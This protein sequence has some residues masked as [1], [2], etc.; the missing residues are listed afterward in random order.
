MIELE[1]GSEMYSR[2]TREERDNCVVLADVTY[3]AKKRLQVKIDAVFSLIKLRRR[4]GVI[5]REAVFVA[6]TGG[7]VTLEVIAGALEEPHTAGRRIKVEY[8][9]ELENSVTQSEVADAKVGTKHVSAAVKASD[10]EKRGMKRGYK[11]NAEEY[12]LNVVSIGPKSLT[13][14][15]STP[16][17]ERV[18]SDFVYQNL[19]L[20]THARPKNGVVEGLLE[21]VPHAVGFYGPDKKKLTGKWNDIAMMLRLMKRLRTAW[22]DFRADGFKSTFRI[23][24]VPG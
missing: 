12:A 2:Q 8:T 22:P 7:T 20:F 21:I 1:V 9:N 18:M 6:T 11:F 10:S 19:K 24:N 15:L 16:D 23:S 5:R 14:D 17:A 13:W 3:E 4:R